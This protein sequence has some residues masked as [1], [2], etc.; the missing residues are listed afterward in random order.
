MTFIG[1]HQSTGCAPRAICILRPQC[2]G[3]ACE[4]CQEPPLDLDSEWRAL[5]A[6]PVVDS[7]SHHLVVDR[8]RNTQTDRV[9][10]TLWCGH[11]HPAGDLGSPP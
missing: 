4:P 1:A 6:L 5:D 8:Q 7:I 11:T 2:H 10:C 9:L 3:C